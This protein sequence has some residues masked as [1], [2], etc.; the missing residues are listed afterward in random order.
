MATKKQFVPVDAVRE[1]LRTFNEVVSNVS[2]ANVEKWLTPEFW[3]MATAAVGNLVAVLALVGWLD[4]SQVETVTKALTALVGAS[5]V[6]LVNGL[7][8]WKFLSG[9]QAVKQQIVAAK[10]RVAEDVMYSRMHGTNN[11]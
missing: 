5:Q 10:L 4:Y 11:R 2:T 7:L 9:Q 3:T 6:I 1:D 8:V